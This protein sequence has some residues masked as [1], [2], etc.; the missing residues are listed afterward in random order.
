MKYGEKSVHRFSQIFNVKSSATRKSSC[1]PGDGPAASWARTWYVKCFGVL[2]LALADAIF[3]RNQRDKL[4]EG[5]QNILRTTQDFQILSWNDKVEEWNK[6]KNIIFWSHAVFP[7]NVLESILETRDLN[8]QAVWL[9]L[10]RLGHPARPCSVWP[11]T[12]AGSSRLLASPIRERQHKEEDGKVKRASIWCMKQR[13]CWTKGIKMSCSSQVSNS[14]MLWSVVLPRWCA[15]KRS[16]RKGSRNDDPTK[17]EPLFVVMPWGFSMWHTLP[18][19]YKWKWV[20]I[21]SISSP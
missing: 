14:A 1:P 19:L 12:S 7:V 17:W 18:S 4:S 9:T 3:Q 20:K 6:I 16:L 8:S 13:T 11:A 2:N 15:Q 10:M 5:S 21:P